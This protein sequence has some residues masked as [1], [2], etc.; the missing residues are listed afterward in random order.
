MRAAFIA[1]SMYSRIPMP[2]FEWKEEDMKY[3]LCF[4]AAIGIVV[5]A[6]FYGMFLLLS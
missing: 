1:F 5:G 3:A 6:V 4:F 2:M